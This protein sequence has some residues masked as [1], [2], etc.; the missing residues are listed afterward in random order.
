MHVTRLNLLTEDDE[1]LAMVVESWQNVQPFFPVVSQ[2]K[3]GPLFLY[4][5][6]DG[7]VMTVDY[8]WRGW[9]RRS[10]WSCQVHTAEWTEALCGPG[11]SPLTIELVLEAA[12]TYCQTGERKRSLVWMRVPPLLA[13]FPHLLEG[14]RP[15]SDD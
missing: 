11:H 9:F 5:E 8:L 4:G 1:R 14:G 13:E 6:Q 15:G 12:L 3:E 10:K 7:K 2:R